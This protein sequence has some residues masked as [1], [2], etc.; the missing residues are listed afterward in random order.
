[1]AD[2][3]KRREL[4][5]RTPPPDKTFEKPTPAKDEREARAAARLRAAEQVRQ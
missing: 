1:M 4:A 5:K 3:K 2:D